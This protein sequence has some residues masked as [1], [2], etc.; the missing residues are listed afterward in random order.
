MMKFLVQ[1]IGHSH[2][3]TAGC[4]VVHTKCSSVA[5]IYSLPYHAGVGRLIAYFRRIAAHIFA[6]LR[7]HPCKGDPHTVVVYTNVIESPLACCMSQ[8]T[9]TTQTSHP[10]FH[11]LY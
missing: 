7:Q 8:N 10:I 4:S 9:W 5:W 3:H 11:E 2:Q 6:V 1:P